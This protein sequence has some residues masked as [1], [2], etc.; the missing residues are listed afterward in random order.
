MYMY[1]ESTWQHVDN[2]IVHGKI[3]VLYGA[4]HMQCTRV[5]TTEYTMI[6]NFYPSTCIIYLQSHGSSD[7]TVWGK[8]KLGI[9]LKIIKGNLLHC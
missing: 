2:N 4:L 1:E 6:V 5:M 3:D 8:L 9:E 7:N